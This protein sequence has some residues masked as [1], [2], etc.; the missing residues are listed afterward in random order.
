M[1]AYAGK[2]E[3]YADL[4]DEGYDALRELLTPYVDQRPALELPPPPPPPEEF[5]NANQTE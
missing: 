3:L 1:K 5:N 4:T 2:I